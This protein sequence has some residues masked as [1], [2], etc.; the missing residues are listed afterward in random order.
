LLEEPYPLNYPSSAPK[1]NRK[2]ADL[3][4]TTV[5]VLDDTYGK[6]FHVFRVRTSN[7]QKGY[8]LDGYGVKQTQDPCQ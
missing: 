6:D 7:G 2:L 4:D 1:P 3:V 5:C 8:V